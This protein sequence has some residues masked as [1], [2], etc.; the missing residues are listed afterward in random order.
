MFYAAL[1]DM[2][3]SEAVQDLIQALVVRFGQRS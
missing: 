2:A 1:G 3:E